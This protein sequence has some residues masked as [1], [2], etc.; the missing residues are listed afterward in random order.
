MLSILGLSACDNQNTVQKHI[1]HHDDHEQM[2]YSAKKLIDIAGQVNVQQHHR[3][4][5][6]KHLTAEAKQY[7]G[8]YHTKIDC[9]GQLIYCDEG[10]ADLVLNLLPDGTAHRV[11]I[12][13]GEMGQLSN[14]LYRQYHWFYDESRHEVI[15][16]QDDGIQL[17]FKVDNAGHLVMNTDK[18]LT[19]MQAN[20]QFYAQDNNPQTQQN[21][22]LVKAP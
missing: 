16:E 14:N 17:F 9:L 2:V 20:R 19:V 22:I 1:S 6:Q 11:I 4:H 13:L 10:N 5:T 3:E 8:R 15:L 7:I 12:H 18:R 21:Y